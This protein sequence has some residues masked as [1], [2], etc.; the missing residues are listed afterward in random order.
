VGSEDARGLCGFIMGAAGGANSHSQTSWQQQA[1]RTTK[2][3]LLLPHDQCCH[4]DR[5]LREESES[6]NGRGPEVNG[7]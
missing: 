1:A 4:D 7:C 5:Q 6:G 3:R 2:E